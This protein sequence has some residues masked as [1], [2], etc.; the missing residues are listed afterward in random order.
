VKQTALPV[1]MQQP[2]HSVL[3][4]IL[5]ITVTA[6]NAS[7]TARPVQLP[8]GAVNATLEDSMILPMTDA[9]I[10]LPTVMV[11][12][13]PTIV[14]EVVLDPGIGIQLTLSAL[15][16]LVTAPHVLMEPAARHAPVD[17]TI[18]QIVQLAL[19][20]LLTATHVLIPMVARN[21]I[22]DT[23]WILQLE[24][25]L[26]AALLPLDVLNAAMQMFVMIVEQQNI[27]QMM[28]LPR[29]VPIA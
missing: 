20:V 10:V 7:A 27:S 21:V 5:L 17:I 23:T 2:A 25:V 28:A 8:L 22:Q 16:A 3:M 1:Q 26:L 4:D 24:L 15:T 12:V 29:P 9:Q 18:T 6:H 13:Q 11:A 14:L 19:P